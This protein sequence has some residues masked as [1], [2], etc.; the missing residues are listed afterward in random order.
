MVTGHRLHQHFAA[1]ASEQQHA[2]TVPSVCRVSLPHSSLHSLPVRSSLYGLS[3]V[4]QDCYQTLILPQ[5][6]LLVGSAP[7]V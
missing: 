5:A 4:S 1:V 3:P 6:I 2:Q 7:V